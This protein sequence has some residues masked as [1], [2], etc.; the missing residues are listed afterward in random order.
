MEEGNVQGGVVTMNVEYKFAGMEDAT[1]IFELIKK[2]VA[3]MDAIGI[4]Q[5]DEVYPTME[6]VAFDIEEH[7]LQ[8]GRIDGNI[9][10][11]FSLN[12]E[13]DEEYNKGEWIENS[14]AFRIVHRLVVHPAYQNLGLGRHALEYI[15]SWL[16]NEGMKSSRLD[17]FQLNPYAQKLYTKMGYKKVG[18]AHFRKGKFDLMEKQLI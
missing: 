6:G 18:V 9:A 13:Y 2:A 11:I 7:T 8:V 4:P 14:G 15:H 12:L 16:A 1:E 5:W 10:V 17:V 3:N